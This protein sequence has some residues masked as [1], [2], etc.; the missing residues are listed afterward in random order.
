MGT[1][2]SLCIAFLA[3]Y[4]AIVNGKFGTLPS[5]QDLSAL[6][7]STASQ[8]YD[9][10]G[11][12]IGQFFL[13]ERTEVK[14]EALPQSL[15]Y[16]LIST[17]D[18]RFYEHEGVDYPSLARV[19]FKSLIRGD[20]RFGGG[21]TLSQQIIKNFYA[22]EQYAFASILINKTKESLVARKLEKI[23]S[24]A[25]IIAL[26]LNTV[27]FGENA[28]GIHT[29]SKRFFSKLPTALRTEESA[30]LVAMLKA[31]TRYN[32]RL[33]P[34][35]ALNRRNLVLGQMVRYGLIS[36]Q[37]G[38]SL[39]QL[40]LGLQYFQQDHHDGIAPYFRAYLRKQV[41]DWA[42][43]SQG[44]NGVP[45][46]IYRDGLKIY[47]TIDARLQAH[48]EKAVNGEMSRIQAIFDKAYRG[49]PL[50]SKVR[51]AI[52]HAFHQSPRYLGLKAKG[53]SEEAIREVFNQPR[54]MEVFSYDGPQQVE[55][56]PMD[57]LIYHKL[58]F[59]TGLLAVSPQNG[60]IKAW[61]GGIDH[62]FF[63][64]DHITSRRQ[65]GS[66]FK[67]IVYAAALQ[68]G[69]DPCSYFSNDPNDLVK[70]DWRP[71]NADHSYGGM[72]TMAEALKR[73]AN[74][75]SVQ[76]FEQTGIR[77][78]AKMSKALGIDGEFPD[79]LTAVLGTKEATLLE[80]VGAYG[81]LSQ[82]G[83]FC[84]PK[85]I[86]KIEDKHGNVIYRPRQERHGQVVLQRGQAEILMQMLQDAINEGT[87][88]KLRTN[89]NISIPIA[90]KTGTTQNQAD[91]WFVGIT[92][93][94]VTGV[95]FGN[96]DSRVHFNSM[97]SGQASST[98][99][100]IWANFMK[101]VLQDKNYKSLAQAKFPRPLASVTEQLDC[102]G[103]DFPKAPEEFDYWYY[104]NREM[105]LKAL[106]NRRRY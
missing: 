64:Y 8:I 15:I 16:A 86:L 38:D 58:F 88:R 87:G 12:A 26:Y 14:F 84:E 102:P 103:L 23:Y 75:A 35:R 30:L 29:A 27:S 59:Q 63:Q 1:I 85:L 2:L 22:R 34:E 72:L 81:T 67:P 24:K 76:L 65:T 57:S 43:T 104:R 31:P 51:A 101:R 106:M 79:N 68:K 18:A 83:K 71:R 95:W 41:R 80:M 48:A 52:E 40:P 50:N 77:T 3:L 42:S 56:S 97:A 69:I 11:K 89:Y 33:H 100:P 99:L 60:H 7:L 78:A 90:G 46:N 36:I 20:S 82:Q 19:F 61:V 74:V 4:L 98:A 28:Y 21:S 96:D 105:L 53:L 93:K 91:A 5:E 49:K 92:P 70:A 47:T 45:Y 32:P 39:K 25:E 13:E 62:R 17:E 54:S 66:A 9:T 73:S 10:K 94:L 55:M 37:E 6:Q 44:P